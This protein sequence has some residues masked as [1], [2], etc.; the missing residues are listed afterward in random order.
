MHVLNAVLLM[1]LGWAQEK[2]AL[3]RSLE[4]DQS[5][6]TK[7]RWI[8]RD[9][10]RL[11][12]I[13]YRGKKFFVIFRQGEDGVS[14]IKC[15]EPHSAAEAPERLELGFESFKRSRIFVSLIQESCME[16]TAHSRPYLRIDPRIGFTIPDDPKDLVKNKK[17]FWSP[18][19][20]FGFYGEW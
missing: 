8:E 19:S 17:V 1:S 15:S 6:V 16:G 20:G 3:E 2:S 9:G 12:E 11:R 5:V 18:A 4:Q 7:E 13:E 10:Q 14:Q